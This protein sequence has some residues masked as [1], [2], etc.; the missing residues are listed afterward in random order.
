MSLW[1]LQS[2]TLICIFPFPQ[3]G[4]KPV[5]LNPLLN[6]WLARVRGWLTVLSTWLSTQLLQSPFILCLVFSM[7]LFQKL[8]LNPWT[9]W[10]HSKLCLWLQ[11][12]QYPVWLCCELHLPLTYNV[13]THF[14]S[15]TESTVIFNQM[16][17][18]DKQGTAYSVL[19]LNQNSAI[20]VSYWKHFS[21]LHQ[22]RV[23]QVILCC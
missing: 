7:Y 2:Q 23:V 11:W 22:A 10:S 14:C 16:L 5:G 20:S 8:G 12:E 18:V 4:W 1:R 6:C 21:R 17:V 13:S 19:I 15:S 3:E 9:V